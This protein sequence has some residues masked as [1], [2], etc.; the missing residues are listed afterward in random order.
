MDDRTTQRSST[1]PHRRRPA[2]PYDRGVN[3]FRNVVRAFNRTLDEHFPLQ[4]Y[5]DTLGRNR[6]S[7]TGRRRR[8]EGCLAALAKRQSQIRSGKVWIGFP[9]LG[10]LFGRSRSTA[11]R[12]VVDLV[13]AQLIDRDSGGGK[14]HDEFDRLVDAAN[15]YSVPAGHQGRPRGGR[16]P[17]KVKPQPVDERSPGQILAQEVLERH[18]AARAGP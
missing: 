15:G 4:R 11:Y 3:G 16:R 2:V 8:A 9:A 5:Q 6:T 17:R 12:A 7:G 1:H 13:A 10:E 14:A 18:R